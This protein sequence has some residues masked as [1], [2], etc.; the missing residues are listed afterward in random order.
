[1]HALLV[2]VLIATMV[3]PP[4]EGGDTASVTATADTLADAGPT[5]DRL[6]VGIS[7]ALA[8]GEAALVLSPSTFP[9]A[10]RADTTVRPK[11]IEYSKGYET[12]MQIHK[13][14]SYATLP[15]FALQ[16]AAGAELY[17]K[18]RYGAPQWAQSLHAPL[19]AV[20]GGLFLVNTVTGVWNMIESRKDRNGRARRYIHGSLMILADAGFVW[21]A[22]LAPGEEEGFTSTGNASQHRTVAITSMAI[23]T[24]SYI[25]MLVWK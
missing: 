3:P 12:R 22:A 10:L 2:G 20:I 21:T 18:G 24:A 8:T 17:S 4:P 25:M 14:A 11:A 15:L 19:G 6:T 7:H 5:P 16:Y 13:I 23:A 1:M 9:V